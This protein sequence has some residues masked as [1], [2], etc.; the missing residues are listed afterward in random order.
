LSQL[1]KGEVRLTEADRQSVPRTWSGNSEYTIVEVHTGTCD[2]VGFQASVRCTVH[3]VVHFI[4]LH[5]S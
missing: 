1:S 5:G 4:T 2:G 3:I